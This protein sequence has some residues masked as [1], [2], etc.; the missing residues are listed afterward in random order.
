MTT[1]PNDSAIGY[2]GPDHHAN[3][4]TKREYFAAMA[5]QGLIADGAA[6]Y[7]GD[8]NKHGN[9]CDPAGLADEAVELADALIYALNAEPEP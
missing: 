6:D 9:V 7:E 8:E 3:G 4:L 5:M 1:N 2:D